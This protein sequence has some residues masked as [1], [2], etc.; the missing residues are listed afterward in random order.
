MVNELLRAQKR[1]RAKVALKKRKLHE[2]QALQLQ[3]NMLKLDEQ[4]I[5]LETTAQQVDTIDA[6]R[7]AN[8]A[9]KAMQQQI[10][11]EDIETLLQDTAE[12]NA[13]V[14]SIYDTIAVRSS[15]N[16]QGNCGLEFLFHT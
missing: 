5:A 3:R 7:I 12:A 14:V 15:S 2:A 8:K 9:V 1:D 13:Y 16:R 6:L 11:L 4:I 10:P